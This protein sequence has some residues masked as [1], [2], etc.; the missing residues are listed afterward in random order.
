[1]TLKKRK[2]TLFDVITITFRA[3][4]ILCSIKFF[5]A[6]FTGILPAIQVVYTAMFIERSIAVAQGTGY[7]NEVY[8]PLIV[9]LVLV[10]SSLI[11]PGS[12]N[13]MLSVRL[14]IELFKRFRLAI[15]KHR[16]KL[17]YH[18]VEDNDTYDL[19]MRVSDDPGTNMKNSF[20][21]LM[22]L[23]QMML[24]IV[25]VIALLF[26][27]VVGVA[28]IILAVSVPILYFAAKNGKLNY[29]G[30][31]DA[32][33]FVRRYEYLGEV[34]TQRDAVDER[35]VFGFSEPVSEKYQGLFDEAKHILLK[36]FRQIFK[37]TVIADVATIF[38]SILIAVLMIRPVLSGNLTF[39]LYVALV[40]AIFALIQYSARRI[41]NQ[42]LRL[43]NT[44]QYMRDLT[45]F[46]ALETIEGTD[47]PPSRNLP[48][49]RQISFK[50]VHFSYP[51]LDYEVLKGVSFDIKPGKHY[52]I[53]GANGAGKSTIIKLLT[54][55][56]TNYTGEIK[57]NDRELKTIPQDML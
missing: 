55:L 6:F 39:P 1:M 31:T 27:H 10:A 22:W 47:L 3:S 20:D 41:P 51:G 14:K 19:I 2:Y 7:T 49:I 44:A 43:S 21:H 17:A 5:I 52:A 35:S 29:Q 53:V 30:Y 25:S 26:F 40:G 37:R 50:N 34:L 48:E 15:T 8:M 46:C 28:F 23:V 18:Y 38:L 32:R 9:L 54:G 11:L 16:A 33:K 45:K 13:Q 36:T 4:P 12:V 56:Y 42:V 57:I 24:N